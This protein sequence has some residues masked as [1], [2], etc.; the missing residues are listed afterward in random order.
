[1][2]TLVSERLDQPW[3][4]R[5]Y[6]PAY[7]IAEAA[8]YAPNFGS[9]GHCLHNIEASLLQ[10]RDKRVSLDYLQLIDVAVVAAFRK[11]DVPHEIYSGCS[12]LCCTV[13]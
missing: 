12:R 4:R 5:L 8:D 3:L 11:A 7:Q 13:N 1:M 2:V 9:D 10:Q 6:L